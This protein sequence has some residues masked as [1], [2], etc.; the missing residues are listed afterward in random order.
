MLRVALWDCRAGLTPD[1]SWCI[2]AG[3]EP[4]YLPNA[5]IDGLDVMVAGPVLDR[6]PGKW[7]EEWLVELPDDDATQAWVPCSCVDR[8]R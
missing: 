7:G 1:E 6:R 5:A 2:V 4:V 8:G 3:M